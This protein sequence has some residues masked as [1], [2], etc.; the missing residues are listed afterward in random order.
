MPRAMRYQ[1]VT[2]RVGAAPTCKT[3]IAA[4]HLICGY[5]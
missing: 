2:N 1:I 3:E 4:N 5:F